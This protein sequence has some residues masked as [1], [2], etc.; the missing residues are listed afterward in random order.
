MGTDYPTPDGS[1]V[2]DYVHVNDLADAHLRAM[3][4]L[5][6]GGDSGA[7]N[8]ATGRGTSVLELLD[9]VHA[10]TG[11][12]VN[13]MHAPRVSRRS[14]LPSSAERRVLR[15]GRSPCRCVVIPPIGGRSLRIRPVFRAKQRTPCS[16]A[17]TGIPWWVAG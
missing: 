16:R 13:A 2:R 8:L 1:A 17:G 14:T 5:L 12:P 15:T 11:K 4:H 3:A 6:K 7:F 10:A 9:A